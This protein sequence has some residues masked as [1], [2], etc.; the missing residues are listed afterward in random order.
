MG[1][2]QY[3]FEAHEAFTAKR[4]DQSAEEVFTQRACH[5]SMNPHGVKTREARD[6]EAHPHSVPVVFAL[7]VSGSMGQ[8]PHGL[9]TRTM[10]KFM[11]KVTAVLPDAQ[12]CFMAVGN[13]HTD[14]SPLQVG[15]F[16]SEAHAIDQWLSRIHL[17]GEGGG[18]GESYDLAMYFGAHHVAADAFEKRGKKG[19]FF[20]TGD[21]PPF[22]RSDRAVMT[23]V[24]G[25][26]P[27]EVSDIYTTVETLQKRWHVF[28][29]IPDAPRAKQWGVGDIWDKILHE[30]AL[31]LANPEETAVAAALLVAITEGQLAA[32]VDIANAAQQ[33]GGFHPEMCAALAKK[34]EVYRAALARGPLALPTRMGERSDPGVKG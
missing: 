24:L 22:S 16:E 26:A 3:S 34:L 30:A 19:Y 20:I 2:G 7:D 1:Y 27:A 29:L 11:Q 32:E 10:P 5:Q 25:A 6:S 33:L 8:I 21:E 9:A 28:F 18:L 14:R 23:K 15:Q 31:V 17:E 4:A 13:G 12:V